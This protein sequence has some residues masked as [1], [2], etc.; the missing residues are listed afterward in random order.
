MTASTVP[1]QERSSDR[2]NLKQSASEVPIRRGRFSA[3]AGLRS[4]E[5]LVIVA[6][7][8]GL[9][10]WGHFTDWSIPKFS[11]L[12]GRASGEQSDW[13]KEHNVPESACI[14][15]NPDL[16]PRLKDF[17]WCKEHGVAQCPL[18]HPEVAQLPGRAVVT[19]DQF[20]RAARA[21][22]LMP[23]PE[24][25]SRC[26]LHQRRIQFASIE[27][28][29]KSGVDIAVAQEDRIIE[30]ITANGE[31]VYDPTRTAHLASRLAGTVWRVEKQ[32]GE[33]VHQGEVLALVDAAEVG[34]AKR[35]FLEAII[36]LRLRRTVLERLN[37]NASV[38]PERSI[39][40]GNAAMQEA[41]ARLLGAQQALINMGFAIG[42]N[43]FKDR[44]TDEIA[45]RLRVLGLPERLR[46]GPTAETMTSNLL[47][48]RSPIEGVVAERN[49]VEGEVIDAKKILFTITDPS[50][51]WLTLSVRQEEVQYVRIGL[52]VLYR[53]TEATDDGEVRGKV[54]WISTKAD[55]KTRTV[56][57]RVDLPNTDG[58]LKSNTFGAGRIVL[59][60][61]PKAI[62][63]PAEAVHWDGCCHVVFVRDKNFFKDGTPKFFHV[64]KVRPGVRNGDEMEIIVGV[65]PGEVV[66]A[67]NS[68][69][70]EAQL[71]KGNLGSGC[72][73]ADGK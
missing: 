1:Q 20:K 2:I 51:M 42:L 17:G 33:P 6:L 48:L 44:S 29:E 73:C 28:M 26:K 52:P 7:L 16:V 3:L 40:E 10:V 47:P 59:R 23:R 56:N 8:S 57:V 9:A 50:R 39:L 43:E 31:V 46:D 45:K 21:L 54:G 13:C 24:N 30:A 70:L 27:E 61:E 62:V 53:P 34:R 22:A 4:V 63:V 49:A 11:V 72:G 36:Q 15:C 35:E 41:T 64:R 58:R 12:I 25:N 65:L 37:S 19:P 66:A 18:H 32:I 69:V 55:E 5:T 14:E 38:V 71:L 67:K 60:D 68:V